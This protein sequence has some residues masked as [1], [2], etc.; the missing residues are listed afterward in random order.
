MDHPIR[1]E[2]SKPLRDRMVQLLRGGFSAPRR[3]NVV[4]VC[5]GNNP[6]HK[7]PQFVEYCNNN[8]PEFRIMLPEYAMGDRYHDELPQPFNL[9]SF[10]ELI[11][12]ISHSIVIFPEAAGSFAETGYFSAK[13]KLASISLLVLNQEYQGSQGFIGLG[14]AKLIAERSARSDPIY[15]NYDAPNFA[16]IVQRLRQWPVDGYRRSLKI[17][18]FNEVSNIDLIS[19]ILK[20]VELSRL[21]TR[22]DIVSLCQSIFRGH[23]KPERIRELISVMVGGKYLMATGQMGH[24]KLH[25]TAPEMLKAMTGYAT[26]ENEIRLEIFDLISRAG[27][28]MAELLDH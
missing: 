6:E 11:A 5:G 10:E 27:P 26:P 15:I 4:F 17:E 18:S 21:A 22:E 3:T 8:A 13:D 19:I 16:Q 23:A 24:Y 1:S 2:I 28:I 25:P 14:P 7:R 12:D 9:A 20:I